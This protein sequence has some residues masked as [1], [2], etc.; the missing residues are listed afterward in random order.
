MRASADPV[1]VRE[2]DNDLFHRRVLEYEAKGYVARRETYTIMADMNPETGE[3][4]HLYL[5]E[6]IMPEEI[7]L[8]PAA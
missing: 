7:A 6:M 8:R 2:W 3:V 5:I 1:L 4:V